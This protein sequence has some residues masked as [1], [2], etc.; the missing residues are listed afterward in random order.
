MP[1]RDVMDN[2]INAERNRV[3][4]EQNAGAGSWGSAH[5]MY[6]Q[7]LVG[8]GQPTDQTN[9]GPDLG[10]QLRDFARIDVEEGPGLVAWGI[11]A[12]AEE[13]GNYWFKYVRWRQSTQDFE[14][15]EWIDHGTEPPITG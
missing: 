8:G 15:T 11:A 6:G 5:P 2:R 3:R 14:E 7:T 12:E 4:A 9:P 1:S 13:G 10:A